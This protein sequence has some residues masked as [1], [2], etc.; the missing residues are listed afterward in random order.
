MNSSKSLSSNWYK[1]LTLKERIASL[2]K[3]HGQTENGAIHTDLARNKLQKWQSQTP[4]TIASYFGQ[5]LAMDKITEEE[6]LYLLG[7]P[8]EALKKR[9]LDVPPW[10]DQL[11]Q[12]FF[13]PT[14]TN[15]NLL[16]SSEQIEKQK[17]VGFLYAIE[18]LIKQG[19]NRIHEEVQGLIQ[20]QSDLPF[21]PNTVVGLMFAN[22]AGQLLWRLSRT[23]VLELNVARLQG[24]LQGNTS[25][26]RFFSFLQRLHDRDVALSLL[27]EYPVLARQLVICTDRW[28]NFSLEFLQHL[29]AD[30]DAIRTTLTPENNPGVLVQIDSSAGDKHRG[31]RSVIVAT[32]SSGFKVVY[33][34][35]SLAV[36]VHFQELLTWLNERGNHPPFRTLKVIDRTTYGWVEFVSA[37]PCHSPEEVERFYQRQGG[38]LALLYAIEATDFHFENLIAAGEHP[39]LIDLESLFHPYSGEVNNQGSMLAVSQ[40]MAY[41]VLRVGLL[42]QRVWANAESEGVDISGLGAV[43]GQISPNP[44]PSW[45]GVGTDEMRFTRQR[46]VMPGGQNRPSI[47]ETDVN[48]LDYTEAIAT[49]FTT[50]YQLLL[51]YR[52]ELLGEDGWLA[53]FAEDEVRVILRPTRRYALLLQESFHPDLLRVALDRDRFFDRLWQEV[54]YRDDLIPVIPAERDDLWQGDIPMF[55]T[56]PTSRDLWS[57]TNQRIAD[58]FA[59]PGMVLVQRRLQQLSEEDLARQLWFIRASLTT[60][61]MDGDRAGW[62][63][64]PL[65]ETQLSANREQ[66]LAEACKIG[67]RLE[68]LALRGEEEVNWLGL[69]LINERYWS[70]LPL[71]ID[72]YDGRLGITLFLA[73]L[74]A[75][76]QE[77]RYTN[78]AQAALSYLVRQVEDAKSFLTAIGGFTGWGAIIYTLTHCSQ[79]WQQPDLLAK[80]EEFVALLPE[81]IEKDEQFDV[82]GGAAGCIGSLLSLYRCSPSPDTLTAA[83]QCGNHLIAHA[84]PMA[85]GLGWIATTMGNKALAGFSHGAAGMAWA[86]LELAVVTGEERFQRTALNAIAYERSLFSVEARNW[87]DL[88]ELENTIRTGS[89]GKVSVMTAWCHGAAGIGLARLRALAYLDDA[90]LRGEIATALKTTLAQGFGMNHSLCHGDLGNLELL[91]QAS[92][93]LNE[94]QWHEQVNRLSS[95]IVESIHQRGW[96]CGVP[97]GVETPGLMTGLAGIGY[98]LL[99]LAEPTRVPSVLVLEPPKLDDVG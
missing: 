28:V 78:L 75:I 60:L 36:D 15:A 77:P 55:T 76:A 45:A 87:P 3:V 94:P 2:N 26:E 82:I 42:P 83:I 25:E 91:L 54:P 88:R 97:L 59:E 39:V 37:Q 70:L 86:L 48:V 17:E 31:G 53:R 30:W 80:A 56:R 79:L 85:Q 41:S 62:P 29:C 65:T 89:Q 72:L 49:G 47:N 81:C 68:T 35:K 5:R 90:E 22:L 74:G 12:A 4:F 24:Q 46:M 64:Y 58:F 50:I 93:I 96:L 95:I 84:Q 23:M 71:G 8:I 21:D 10:L 32:F 40:T 52:E 1:T 57:S 44:V 14:T 66:L 19:L 6:L 43:A 38:Y 51:N 9:C 63:T 34:P 27:Q 33:K 16:F 13:S 61:S 98:E 69:T 67:D 73:Y 92:I 18:P 7:E 99:R 11:V 20:R